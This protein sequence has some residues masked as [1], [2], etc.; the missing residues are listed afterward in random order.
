MGLSVSIQSCRPIAIIGSFGLA[1]SLIGLP[2]ANAGRIKQN[3]VNPPTGCDAC[4]LPPACPSNDPFEK[5]LEPV[6]QDEHLIPIS[7]KPGG[8]GEEDAHDYPHLTGWGGGPGPD[9]QYLTTGKH[10]T[11]GP[12]TGSGWQPYTPNWNFGGG[13]GGWGGGSIGGSGGGPGGGSGGSGPGG[14]G[15]GDPGTGSPGTSGPGG[16]DPGG[17]GPFSN[18]PPGGGGDPFDPQPGTGP[19]WPYSPP[20]SGDPPSNPPG[21]PPSDPPGG[22]DPINDP[23]SSL[24]TPEPGTVTLLIFGAASLIAWRKKR[25]FR[26]SFETGK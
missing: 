3:F 14:G 8:S 4:C 18:P 19:D 15:G 21:D 7:Y 17:A 9:G 13:G 24:S 25:F 16:S 20:G 11:F 6:P 2:S 1:I 5:P 12:G 10:A 26:T 23:L 22:G